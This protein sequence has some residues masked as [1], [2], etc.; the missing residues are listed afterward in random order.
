MMD[1]IGAVYK[2]VD[3]MAEDVAEI[4]QYVAKQGLISGL[5]VSNSLG[6]RDI[7]LVEVTRS[8]VPAKKT[9]LLIWWD[10]LPRRL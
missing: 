7:Q 1:M 6:R 5:R 8:R 9:S 2:K 3:R 10:I 4:K